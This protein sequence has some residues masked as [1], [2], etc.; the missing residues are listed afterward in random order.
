MRF[1]STRGESPAVGFADAVLTGLAPDGGLYIPD[2]VPTVSMRELQSWR[3][4][5][6]AELAFKV[7][8]PY[9]DGAIPDLDL[10]QMLFD[11]YSGFSSANVAPLRKLHGNQYVMELYCGPTL[12]FKDFALQLLGRLLDY[13]LIQ[14]QQKVAILGATSGDTGSAALEGCRHS[15]H[16]EL[17]ILHPYKRVSEVQRRQMTTVPGANVHN[18]AVEGNFDDCQKIVKQAF[19]NQ[20]FLPA[21]YQLAAVNSINFARVMAQIVYYFHAALELGTLESGISFSVPT[22]NFG[23]IYA[24]YLAKKMGLPIKQLIIATNKNDILHRF[25]SSNQYHLTAL[26]PTLSP[27]MDIMVSSNFERFMFDMFDGDTSRVRQFVTGLN[28]EA[29]SVTQKQWAKARDHFDSLSVDDATT[30]R[31]IQQVMTEDNFLVDPHTATGIQAATVCDKNSQIPMVTLGTAHPAK[32]GKAIQEAGF[33]C[34]ELPAHIADLFQ[35]QERYQVLPNSLEA[36][37]RFMLAEL[38][39]GEAGQ[40]HYCPV[41]D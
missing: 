21:G 9:V 32:F 39:A 18:I 6:Y 31:V 12:A 16:V 4:L 14:R 15:S 38:V 10:Q 3:G 17:F 27:S 34:P 25:I 5:S 24:G 1:I 23:D 7:I 40:A 22:G 28:Q 13:F 26:E 36:V 29:Q 37:Q 33:A 2:S 8:E 11:S 35:R 41:C 20:S 30:L 19:A